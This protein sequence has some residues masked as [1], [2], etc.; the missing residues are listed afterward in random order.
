MNLLLSH[1]D[2]LAAMCQ[3]HTHQCDTIFYFTRTVVM[4]VF[5]LTQVNCRKLYVVGVLLE[6]RAV[7]Y[8][9]LLLRTQV[10]P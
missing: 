7:A 5:V 8:K 4:F 3:V 6:M 2:S 9:K 10:Y 1:T